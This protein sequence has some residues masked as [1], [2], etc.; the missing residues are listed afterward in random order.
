MSVD[1]QF[2]D[3]LGPVD[4]QVVE[5]TNGV[6]SGAGW[7]TLLALVDSHLI[8]V[9][10]LEFVVK[11]AGGTLR[12]VP[13]HDVVI[14]DSSIDMTLFDGA[15][16]GLVG[17]LD[18]ADVADAL[19]AGSIAAILVYE[20]LTV[21]PLLA[22]WEKAGATIVAGGPVLPEDLLAALDSTD[23]DL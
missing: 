11:D 22:E 18:L 2:G 1:G 19:S 6:V 13:A 4:Y 14:D 20:E 17:A 21:L 23:A 3:R 7:H 16:S 8:H 15:S 9:L 5:F 12:V 10:D